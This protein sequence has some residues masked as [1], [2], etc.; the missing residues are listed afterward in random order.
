MKTRFVSYLL[1]SLFALASGSTFA[2][3]AVLPSFANAQWNGYVVVNTN[4]PRLKDGR[5]AYCPDTKATVE[6]GKCHV[7]D[8]VGRDVGD[9]IPMTEDEYMDTSIRR[10][11]KIPAGHTYEVV[12]IGPNFVG[13]RGTAI[14]V[15]TAIVYV[16]V[17]PVKK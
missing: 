9:A 7:V 4:P 1:A 3:G 2:Q 12:G 11:I 16:R 17:Y 14:S 8:L 13:Y 15:N 6:R 5:P 10:G